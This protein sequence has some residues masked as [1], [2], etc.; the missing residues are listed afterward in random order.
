MRL[1]VY[2]PAHAP[3]Q[4]EARAIIHAAQQ[5]AGL[6]VSVALV[7]ENDVRAFYAGAVPIYLL[8]GAVLA[9]GHPEP[10]ALL[11]VL[12]QRAQAAVVPPE[13]G[14]LFATSLLQVDV[15]RNLNP[16]ALTVLS[17]RMWPRSYARGQLVYR[18]GADAA[19]LF[20]LRQGRVELYHL[21][22]QGKRLK[23]GQVRPGMFFGE[24]AMLGRTI[25]L[26]TAEAA[27][28]SQALALG[29]AAF[30]DLLR[31]QPAIAKYLVQAL[32]RRLL[33]SD[34]RLVGLAYHDAPTRVAAELVSLSQEE[35]AALLP[36]THQALGE[37]CGLLR[38]TVTKALD[39]FQDQGLVELHRGRILL[40]DVDGLRGLLEEQPG[41]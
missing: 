19:E 21:T 7:G 5:I 25:Y 18:Q 3:D 13:A 36:I 12:R 31:E 14:D 1:E 20:L 29:R 24:A 23:L 10:E 11:A 2:L 41:V 15:F 40:R 28:P 34:Q 35:H 33:L 26:A 32:S 6:E 4:Q 16:D 22:R 30:N 27:E 37:R 38:E 9:S 17:E 8:D 39:V